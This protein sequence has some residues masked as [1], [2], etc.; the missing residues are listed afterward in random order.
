MSLATESVNDG[1]NGMQSASTEY[2]YD[3]YTVE[4]DTDGLGDVTMATYPL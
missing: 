2:V 3:L 1:T 4:D